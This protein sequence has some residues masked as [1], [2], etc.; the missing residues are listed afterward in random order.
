MVSRGRG[1]LWRI[2]S[3][4]EGGEDFVCREKK[5]DFGCSFAVLRRYKSP[6][7]TVKRKK[8]SSVTVSVSGPILIT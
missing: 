2:L 7:V 6:A 4:Q 3:P 8:S 1:K 5:V